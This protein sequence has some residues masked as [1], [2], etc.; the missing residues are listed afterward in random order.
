MSTTVETSATEDNENKTLEVADENSDSSTT[1][2]SDDISEQFAPPVKRG[3]PIP[4]PPPVPPSG[5][6]VLSHKLWIGNLD[7][8]LTE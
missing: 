7:K 6:S 2:D 4:I 5:I 8:R 1:S 3:S